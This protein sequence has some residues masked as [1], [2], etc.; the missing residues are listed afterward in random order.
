MDTNLYALEKHV[1]SKLKDARAAGARAALLSSL[2]AKGS[3]RLSLLA[4]VATIWTGR[5]RLFHR[6]SAGAPG[7]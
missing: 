6:V 2:R 7:A 1:Q 5:R 3:T 4:T